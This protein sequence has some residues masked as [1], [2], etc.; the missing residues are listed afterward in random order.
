MFTRIVILYFLLIHSCL[1]LD[2]NI[3]TVHAP[4]YFNITER[5]LVTDANGNSHIF[6]GG[7]HLFHQ[8]YTG[9]QWITETIDSSPDVGYSATATIDSNGF[10]HVIYGDSSDRVIGLSTNALYANNTSG[11]WVIE[12]L[13][14]P[15]Q[16]NG[17]RGYENSTYDSSGVGGIAV[18][19]NNV[20][21]LAYF[22][23]P[24]Y[25]QPQ[26][27]FYGNNDGG[28]WSFQ[29]IDTDL[30]SAISGR[31]SILVD[32][33]D[34]IHIIYYDNN[35][36]QLKHASNSSGDWAVNTISNSFIIDS[37]SAVIDSA[38]NIHVVLTKAYT[39][40]S[41]LEY[42]TNKSG[43]WVTEELDA[44]ADPSVSMAIDNNDAI[45]ISYISSYISAS[46]RI[47]DFVYITN[48]TNTWVKSILK[49]NN[50]LV[51][52]SSISID[53]N[54]N[55]HISYMELGYKDIG[56]AYASNQSG[57]WI[58]SRLDE[59]EQDTALTPVDK[60][61]VEPTVVHDSNDNIHIAYRDG[62]Q[63]P[64]QI[65]YATNQTNNWEYERITGLSEIGSVDK[66]ALI[67]D[68]NNV[69]YIIYGGG[70]RIYY[71]YKS[72]GTWLG[73]IV[74][75]IGPADKAIISLDIDSDNVIHAVYFL[76]NGDLRYA[77]FT[78]GIWEV[79][80]IATTG[81]SFGN[82]SDYS[83]SLTLD[84]NNIPHV[85]YLDRD[86]DL[87]YATN[88]TGL[89]ISTYIAS[90]TNEHHWH[91]KDY[92]MLPN[93]IAHM[94][95][96]S[97]KCIGGTCYNTGLEYASNKSG[98]WKA[99]TID[100]QLH[101]LY[102]PVIQSYPMISPAIALDDTGNVSVSYHIQE[103]DSY[104]SPRYLRTARKLGDLWRVST[105]ETNPFAES[106]TG[107]PKDLNYSSIDFDANG[108]AVIA[109]FDYFDGSLNLAGSVQSITGLIN[110]KVDLADFDFGHVQIGS[111]STA[112]LRIQNLGNSLLQINSIELQDNVSGIY[113][114]DLNGGNKPCILIPTTLNLNEEC[115][116]TVTF[117][118]EETGSKEV[119]L[120]IA[121]NDQELPVLVGSM[122]GRGAS[123]TSTTSGGSSGGGGCTYNPDAKFDPIFPIL[124]L[125]SFLYLW[126]NRYSN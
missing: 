2:W 35:L 90:S 25:N 93:G 19:S 89:W 98:T 31:I 103:G 88:G 60:V 82:Y 67:V 75:N 12:S 109:Y 72:S 108:K 4:K 73:G 65:F 123:V 105:I 30:E 63:F 81:E 20:V 100:I 56:L 52:R 32:S 49:A 116:L 61:G 95:Y 91:D 125:L 18:D 26:E 23:P 104:N 44:G 92:I 124:I 57:Q 118:P 6:Y 38:D 114:I 102:Y 64:G 99:E 8:Y 54:D 115:T 29:K 83:T 59:S 47:K 14:I 53:S 86:G 17:Y 50:N 101:D 68:N 96:S 70:N 79:E 113:S 51:G 9:S 41:S 42:I 119:T 40:P 69:P 3:E 107:Y 21:H 27:L 97:S 80:T 39:S 77:R 111:L 66:I 5:S 78:N 126:R 22:K 84:S 122:T 33:A 28:S 76:R 11:A 55:A 94:V 112:M 1:A 16:G 7:S 87:N 71:A 13:A 110:V 15:N 121:S 85:G 34:S 106:S 117:S 10:F 74:D 62:G 45:H 36:N 43:G 120:V 58:L 37:T 46:Q 48:E 24:A